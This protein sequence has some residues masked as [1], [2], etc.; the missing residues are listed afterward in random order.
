ME[1]VP[2]PFLG[3]PGVTQT[4]DGPLP[5]AKPLVRR[6]SLGGPGLVPQLPGP[7]TLHGHGRWDP[8]PS[9][10]ACAPRLRPP[11]AAEGVCRAVSQVCSNSVPPVGSGRGP[12][13]RV[14]RRS[15]PRAH[16]AAPTT[17]PRAQQL[18]PRCSGWG[19][20]APRPRGLGETPRAVSSV[21][22][23]GG[24]RRRPTPGRNPGL[25]FLLPQCA[26]SA[27]VHTP[28]N[29]PPEGPCAPLASAAFQEGGE[30]ASL[31]RLSVVSWM[32]TPTGG[33]VMWVTLE[34]GWEELR[35]SRR[36]AWV[37]GTRGS[38]PGPQAPHRCVSPAGPA[39]AP[40]QTPK[41]RSVLT[42]SGPG[43]LSRPVPRSRDNLPVQRDAGGKR[44]R[45]AG[46]PTSS[47]RGGG[48][49]ADCK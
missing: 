39:G 45:S 12:R 41:L 24:A 34:S 2:R 46:L 20:G 5:R 38:P 42:A 21:Y 23:P 28:T 44:H 47:P 30:G 36:G 37:Q 40:P 17:C 6:G 18:Q 3:G 27:A 11:P 25:L 48:S 32:L 49:G 31:P 1:A 33:D 19:G 35:P 22:A 15:D 4:L 16:G 26:R 14:S 29:A 43:P 9:S 7:E 8:A 10:P 13:L